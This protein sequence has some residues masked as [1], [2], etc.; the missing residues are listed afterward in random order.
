MA[1]LFLFAFVVF[2]VGA[3]I[4]YIGDRLGT[5]VGKKRLSKFGLRPRHT[6]ILYTTITGGIIPLL[7]L[8]VFV[9]IDHNFERAIVEG[10]RLVATNRHLVLGNRKLDIE[11]EM[12][13]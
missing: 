13:A 9:R 1:T 4:A 5:F 12:L 3:L 6:A 11:N 8:A 10:G 2:V 7:T